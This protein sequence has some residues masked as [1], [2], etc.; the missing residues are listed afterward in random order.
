MLHFQTQAA[1]SQVVWKKMPNFTLFDP[2]KNYAR[3]G[4]HLWVMYCSFTYDQT[5]GMH[6]IGILCATAENS[7]L[8]K[9]FIS[10]A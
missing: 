4:R 7:G 1:Q 10:K 8:L 5:L 3:G 6:L 9:K 2:S